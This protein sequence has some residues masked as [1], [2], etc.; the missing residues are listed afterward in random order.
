[1]RTFYCLDLD[2]TLLD[3][4]LLVELLDVYLAVEHADIARLV[5]AACREVEQ[6]GGSY[7]IIRGIRQYT[8]DGTEQLLEGF[9]ASVRRD[10]RLFLP[11]AQDLLA[12]ITAHEQSWGVLTYGGE[13]WQR[14]KLE[15]LGL[16]D[17]AA[18]IIPQK[19]KGRIIASWLG[20]DGRYRLPREYGDLMVDEVVLVDDKPVEFE[21]LPNDTARGYLVRADGID[22]SLPSQQGEVASNVRIVSSLADVIACEQSRM[23]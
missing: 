4:G 15:I 10:T 11:Y 22:A 5:Q 7:D 20:D 17:Q 9:V 13:A 1:M 6:S 16:E 8:G 21:E 12:A 23:N 18:I 3:T 2:R 19:G 14:A